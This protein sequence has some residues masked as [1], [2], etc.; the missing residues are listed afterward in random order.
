MEVCDIICG[1]LNVPFVGFN[2]IATAIR[3]S[4]PDTLVAAVQGK[5]QSNVVSFLLPLESTRTEKVVIWIRWDS[6]RNSAHASQMVWFD[7]IMKTTTNSC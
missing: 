1:S 5:R 6:Y 2:D 3:Q 4:A 7:L